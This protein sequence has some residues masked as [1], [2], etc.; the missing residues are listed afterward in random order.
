MH[1]DCGGDTETKEALSLSHDSFPLSSC[2]HT[3]VHDEHTL[4]KTTVLS[5]RNLSEE[6]RGA[7][8]PTD[9][10]SVSTYHAN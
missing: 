2:A 7:E 3:L 4:N 5:Y 6:I 10:I 8:Y 9:E 1:Y